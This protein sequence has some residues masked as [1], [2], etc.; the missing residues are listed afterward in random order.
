M[1]PPGIK[2]RWMSSQSSWMNC[3]DMARVQ[4]YGR[5]IQVGTKPRFTSYLITKGFQLIVGGGCGVA[6]H[7]DG[8]PTNCIMQ[9]ETSRS[10]WQVDVRKLSFFCP[11]C[12]CCRRFNGLQ[13]TRFEWSLSLA[14][15][16]LHRRRQ[17]HLNTL[18][19]FHPHHHLV[20][21]A[22]L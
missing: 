14:K 1:R 6:A 12:V 13:E 5:G 11:C 21:T 8:P 17:R 3:S 4:S 9:A 19:L 20:I 22:T 16:R 18:T 15:E 2:V 10:A 7:A